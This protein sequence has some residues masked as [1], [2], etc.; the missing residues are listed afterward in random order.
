LNNKVNKEQSPEDPIAI[1][2]DA[3]SLMFDDAM[4]LSAGRQETKA[5]KQLK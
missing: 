4:N 5:G 1:G 2:C 3:I